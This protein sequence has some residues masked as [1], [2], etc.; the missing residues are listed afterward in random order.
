MGATFFQPPR[1]PLLRFTSPMAKPV[2][3]DVFDRVEPLSSFH[4]T[5]P[6]PNAL[7]VP[8]ETIYPQHILDSLRASPVKLPPPL[9]SLATPPRGFT[10]ATH[11]P[12][13]KLLEEQ[14]RKAQAA[15]HEELAASL[16]GGHDIVEKN[17]RQAAD[18]V[19]RAGAAK[20][21]LN[22]KLE[23]IKSHLK[24]QIHISEP[25]PGDLPAVIPY[26]GEPISETKK[27]RLYKRIQRLQEK[28]ADLRQRIEEQQAYLKQLLRDRKVLEEDEA[29]I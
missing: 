27:R 2:P 29:A 13:M 7:A 11:I 16:A 12:D 10:L 3:E 25:S 20:R 28:E 17:L 22:P 18:A 19:Q 9:G 6:H 15:F 8:V 1:L 26:V 21:N 5:T 24:Q 23:E 14:T 4:G